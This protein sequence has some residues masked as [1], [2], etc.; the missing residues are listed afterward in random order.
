M[1]AV[2]GKKGESSGNKMR[3][4]DGEEDGEEN[5]LYDL[6]INTEWPPEFEVQPRG[7]Q[8]HYASFIITRVI[9]G[10][11]LFLRHFW[12]SSATLS[13]PAGFV[14]LVSKQMNWHLEL[15]SNGKL[16]AVVQD[17]IIEIR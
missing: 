5:I 13:L 3:E 8:K 4:E 9:M 17:Q 11:A 15:A 14:R 16:L 1:A 2:R 10:P 7:N 6:L 12:S